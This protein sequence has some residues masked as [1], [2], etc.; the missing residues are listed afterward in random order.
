VRRSGEDEKNCTGKTTEM[1]EFGRQNKT[2]RGGKGVRQE[3]DR[4]VAPLQ[5]MVGYMLIL[6]NRNLQ[7]EHL[8][9]VNATGNPAM[10]PIFHGFYSLV[11]FNNQNHDHD[12]PF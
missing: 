5:L 3:E 9:Y 6:H 11:I 7:S 2:Q 10:L 1:T 12:C 4:N 8:I